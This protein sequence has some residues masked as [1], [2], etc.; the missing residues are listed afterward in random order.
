MKI[1][2]Y[3]NR[4]CDSVLSDLSK[5]WNGQICAGEKS[6]GKDSCQGDSGGSLYIQETVDSKIKY[7]S[8]GIVSYGDSCGLINKPG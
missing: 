7:V 3:E 8:V 1:T 6:G 5:N 4:D 2:L